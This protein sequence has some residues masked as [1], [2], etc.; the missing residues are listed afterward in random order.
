[1]S[2]RSWSASQFDAPPAMVVP[3][4]EPQQRDSSLVALSRQRAADLVRQ[5]REE[6]E[7]IREQARLQGLQQGLEE[8]RRQMEHALAALKEESQAD[9]RA[10]VARL[11][12]HFQSELQHVKDQ[13]RAILSQL[14]LKA[15]QRA[16]AQ[17]L[18]ER[19]EAL[20]AAINETLAPYLQS[21]EPVQ[22]W[23]HP[24]QVEKLKAPQ[25][26]DVRTESSLGEHEFVVRGAAGSIQ[27]SLESRIQQLSDCLGVSAA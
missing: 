12:E 5:A 11:N 23:L 8:G 6:A 13:L 1:M 3:F 7:Q 15:S 27:G 20:Q 4:P 25:G 26:V 16:W 21:D 18:Q 24:S 9:L 14:V 2:E 10:Q 22:L 19:P 17:L